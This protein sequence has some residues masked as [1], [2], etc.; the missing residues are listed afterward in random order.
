MFGRWRRKEGV[1]WNAWQ[2][3]KRRSRWGGIIQ[4]IGQ[5]FNIGQGGGKRQQ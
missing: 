1:W 3:F 5:T 2:L 4:D